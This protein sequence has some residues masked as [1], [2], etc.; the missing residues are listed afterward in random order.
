VARSHYRT[1]TIA[2]VLFGCTMP[3]PDD[4]PAPEPG[5]PDSVEASCEAAELACGN[6]P[7]QSDALSFGRGCC[8]TTWIPGGTFKMGFPPSDV[9]G[10]EHG[11]F[12]SAFFLDR[13]EITLGRFLTH[14]RN[15]PEPPDPGSGAHPRIAESGWQS[16]WNDALLKT[17][18]N[19][20]EELVACGA[21]LDPDVV[22]A[23]LNG[24]PVED[25][26]ALEMLHRP[27]P[28]LSWF[29]AFAF[30]LWD[31]GR[32]PTEAEWEF[33]ATGGSDDRPYPWGAAD[34]SLATELADAMPEPE[35]VGKHERARGRYGQDDL[36]G[37]VFEWVLDWYAPDFYSTAGLD[38]HD[39]AN[40]SYGAMLS[41][42]LRGAPDGHVDDSDFRSESRNSGAPGSTR[43]A[44]YGVRC[45]RD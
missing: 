15:H 14:F 29:A 11:V 43:F 17:P 20:V 6:A 30:C 12:V 9:D 34:I 31:G 1:L 21:G 38:C 26:A 16:E 22:E 37:G 45:A 40:L 4:D 3:K 25:P 24:E 27:M 33:A 39:C 19:V 41:R 13:F 35:P 18:E 23:V 10:H 8:E 5:R 42:S 28:C 44:P 32:L 7:V 2:W 36:A